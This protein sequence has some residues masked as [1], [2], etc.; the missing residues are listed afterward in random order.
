MIEKN[1]NL[2]YL[3]YHKGN[4]LSEVQ[5]NLLIMAQEAAH[6]AYAPYSKFFVGAA[7]LLNDGSVIKG[8][9]QENASYPNGICAERAVLA[10]YGNLDRKTGILKMAIT[11]LSDHKIFSPATPCGFCRQVMAELEI[12]NT[13]PIE[14]IIGQLE[15][16]TFVF[17]S[18][19]SLLPLAFT[20]DLLPK[21]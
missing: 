17:T 10:T 21:L 15:S 2:S 11:N 12:Q 13:M 1:V 7:I 3:Y 20:K 9:N 5:R 16:P 14:L 18:F 6:N 8:C 4:E 19:Q